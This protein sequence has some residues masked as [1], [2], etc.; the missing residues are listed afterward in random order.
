MSNKVFFR[1]ASLIILGVLSMYVLLK[2]GTYIFFLS[3]VLYFGITIEYAEKIDLRYKVVS[4]ILRHILFYFAIY[5]YSINHD[6]TANPHF[7]ASV[8]SVGLLMLSVILYGY[9]KFII[10][11]VKKR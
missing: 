2:S 11:L 6:T 10:K 3:F 9:N 5:T 4:V 7:N 1:I 8:Y